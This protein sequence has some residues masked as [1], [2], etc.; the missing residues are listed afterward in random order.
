M[1]YKKF[2]SSLIIKRARWICWTTWSYVP[3]LNINHEIR[4]QK[5]MTIDD[6][7]QELICPKFYYFFPL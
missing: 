1:F 3:A 6:H 2:E 5:W 4:S 7:L